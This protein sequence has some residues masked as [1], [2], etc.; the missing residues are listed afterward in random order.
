MIN[1]KGPFVPSK[2]SIEGKYAIAYTS[3]NAEIVNTMLVNA[4]K[5]LEAEGV[6]PKNIIKIKVPGVFELPSVSNRLAS[7]DIDAIITLGCVIR[8]ETPHFD[9]I[10]NSCAKGLTKVSIGKEIPVIFGVLTTNNIQ[11]A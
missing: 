1:K 5:A 4:V 11:Q 2:R 6:N 8:G 3:W 9:F 7:K 10:S